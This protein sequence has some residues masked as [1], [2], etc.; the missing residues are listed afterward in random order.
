MTSEIERQKGGSELIEYRRRL[1]Q[2]GEDLLT[3][4]DRLAA[5]EAQLGA[6]LGRVAALEDELRR[7]ELA[8]RDLE[9]LRRLPF[10]GAM[11]ATRCWMCCSVCARTA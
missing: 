10:W 4:R 3:E 1:Q 5:G 9:R 8:V 6:A 7:Y 2:A 11:S